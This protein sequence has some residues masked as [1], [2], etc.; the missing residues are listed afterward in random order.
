MCIKLGFIIQNYF[1]RQSPDVNDQIGSD[2]W[3][4]YWSIQRDSTTS[5]LKQMSSLTNCRSLL[6]APPPQFI[7]EKRC[8][9][10]PHRWDVLKSRQHH[11]IN[12]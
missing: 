2:T 9:F 4:S 7:I 6:N 3:P 10:A 12:D 5:G 11:K 1:L 8:C